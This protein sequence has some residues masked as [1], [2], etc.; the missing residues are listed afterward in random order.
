M[1]INLSM[2][3]RCIITFIVLIYNW[4]NLNDCVHAVVFN[5]VP[6]DKQHPWYTVHSEK[7][8]VAFLFEI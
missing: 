2:Q 1:Y 5:V 4:S 7:L 8:V 6:Q 3:A